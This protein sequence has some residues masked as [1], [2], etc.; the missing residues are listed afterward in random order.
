MIWCKEIFT[1]LIDHLGD[2]SL[3][4]LLEKGS[5]VKLENMQQFRKT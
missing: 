4:L 3:T 2:H 1:S 5:N